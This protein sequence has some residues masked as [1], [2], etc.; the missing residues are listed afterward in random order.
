VE[1]RTN[2]QKMD[3]Q[4]FIKSVS[5]VRKGLNLPEATQLPR[6]EQD[7]MFARYVDW[8]RVA[9]AAILA[10]DYE[11]EAMLREIGQ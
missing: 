4:R 7:Q 8:D 3:R 1:T 9:P 6:E 10:T 2:Q 5:K 11:V